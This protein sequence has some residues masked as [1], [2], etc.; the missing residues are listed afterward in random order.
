MERENS[1]IKKSALLLTGVVA[2]IA[3]V[4]LAVVF[5]KERTIFADVAF[6]L[7]CI[8]NEGKLA[9]QSNRFGAIVTQVFPLVACRL[10]LPLKDVAILY[11]TGF[12]LWYF[13]VFLITSLLLKNLRISLALLLFNTL[14]VTHTF[15]WVM[16]ELSQGVAYAFLHFALLLYMARMERIPWYLWL[17]AIASTAIVIFF[18][19]LLLFPFLF[20]ILFF[21]LS[22]KPAW[23]L[24]AAALICYI[25]FYMLK[26]LLLPTAYESGSMGGL[27]NFIL[28][29][30]NYFTIQ[31]NKDLL[32]YFAT[33][34]YFIPV[35]LAAVTVFYTRTKEWLKL[36]LVLCFFFGYILLIN[37]S[38]AQGSVH[39]YIE[40]QYL[41]FSIFL[42][43]PLA[44]DL[45]PAI[46]KPQLAAAGICL[47]IAIGFV[48]IWST[49]TPYTNRVDWSR[50]FLAK[51][52]GLANKKLIVPARYVPIDTMLATW[53]SP[54]EFWLLSTIEQG[55]T[56]SVIVADSDDQFD[57]D[58]N[59][60][61]CFIS[62]WWVNGYDGLNPRYFVMKDSS[63]YVKYEGE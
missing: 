29:F 57:K 21:A 36:A 27:K 43:V 14:M 6:H 61:Q 59:C 32:H 42:I 60:R 40:N 34:Y 28:L 18:H 48:R 46:N 10:N 13:S 50:N 30:P 5:Y 4:A 26:Q 9:I 49:H 15:Y 55:E 11:S 63:S 37:V 39:F 51:T 38:Y 19:P 1:G 33:E 12:V 16:S 56:R 53:S 24:Y 52:A 7:F 17:L 58:M 25:V 45:L 47:V 3:M 8:V 54:Y 22:D 31:T 44:F 23:K 35:L 62:T 2:Y 20:M 41:I